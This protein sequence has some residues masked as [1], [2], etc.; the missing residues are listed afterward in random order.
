MNKGKYISNIIG[1]SIKTKIQKYN[2]KKHR[3]C[4]KY[5]R[6]WS[7]YEV[8]IYYLIIYVYII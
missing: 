7:N 1:H 3:K 2:S 6:W 8:C 4:E 5:E